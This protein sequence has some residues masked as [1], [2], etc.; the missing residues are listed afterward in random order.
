MKGILS[1]KSKKH[2]NN[3]TPGLWTPALDSVHKHKV[4]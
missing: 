1:G 4:D 2:I 3:I